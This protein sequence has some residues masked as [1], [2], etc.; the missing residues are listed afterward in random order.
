MPEAIKPGDVLHVRTPNGAV[1]DVRI[2]KVGTTTAD[3][4]VKAVY[5]M[6]T[7]PVI[8]G[9]LVTIGIPEKAGV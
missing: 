8:P 4:V 3:A 7:E 9:Q 1:L 2:E 5:K 6:G